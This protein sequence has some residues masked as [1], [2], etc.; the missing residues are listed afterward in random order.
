MVPKLVCLLVFH[1]CSYNSIGVVS[2][3]DSNNKNK[4]NKAPAGPQN[5]TVFDKSL[6]AE[7]ILA[8]D[9]LKNYQAFFRE[10]DEYRF[11]G[12]VLGYVTPWNN[13]GYDIAKIFGNKFTHISPVWLQIVRKGTKKYEVR[14]THDVDKGWVAAVRNA[15][16]ER[17][18]KIVPRILF[19]SWTGN[20]YSKLLSSQQEM[21]ALV[22]AFV[23]A[24][25][26]FGFDGYVLEIWSQ[27]AT[28][29]PFDPLVGLIRDIADG[30]STESLETILVI[31][32]KRGKENLFNDKHFDA[33]YDFVT[34]FSLMTYDFSNPYMPGANAPLPW[35]RDCVTSLTSDVD[36][37]KKILTGLNFYGN[38]Y[39]TN[40]GGPILAHDYISRLKLLKKGKLK[41]DAQAA[42]HFFEYKDKDKKKHTVFYPTLYSI[43]KRLELTK[44]LNTGISIWELG[45]GLDYFYDLL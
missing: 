38:D 25:K 5:Y 10:T 17:K 18:L 22:N 19:E 21:D 11:D 44:D 40:G 7:E 9:V 32:P 3:S 35:V 41:Y 31:P 42:E 37:R 4:N 23:E 30:L 8:E 45:Q 27:I 34:A 33:L 6:V 13:H 36:K 14:G 43:N 29:I 12:L 28:A 1:I 16:R 2:S 24:A 20:D 39:V 26:E 15:G